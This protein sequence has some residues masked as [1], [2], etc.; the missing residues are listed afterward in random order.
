LL[1]EAGFVALVVV[2]LLVA[3]AGDGFDFVV[4]FLIA[5]M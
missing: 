3:G 5:V 2:L 1:R 4:V